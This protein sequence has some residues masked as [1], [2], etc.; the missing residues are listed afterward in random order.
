MNA[1]EVYVSR[2]IS[3][4]DIDREISRMHRR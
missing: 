4:Q 1:W 3:E 2:D